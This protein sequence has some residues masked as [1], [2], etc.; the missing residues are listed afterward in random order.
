MCKFVILNG[1]KDPCSRR[2]YKMLHTI[3]G[4]T[5]GSGVSRWSKLIQE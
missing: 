4:A 2:T 1:V 5:T 3:E